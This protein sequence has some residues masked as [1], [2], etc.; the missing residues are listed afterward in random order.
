MKNKVTSGSTIVLQSHRDINSSLYFERQETNNSNIGILEKRNVSHEQNIEL[1]DNN[2]H[3]KSTKNN[4]MK[5]DNIRTLYPT[6]NTLINVIDVRQ[7]QYTS[8]KSELPIKNKYKNYYNTSLQLY[9]SASTKYSIL[10]DKHSEFSSDH[11]SEQIN[12]FNYEK[13]PWKTQKYYKIHTS[14][15]ARNPYT[16]YILP[17]YQNN[18]LRHS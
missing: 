2:T 12:F 5:Q 17:Y 11:H 7:Y 1:W 8:N 14:I 15:E 6:V 9:N 3:N 18:A 10:R 16:G 4:K 13:K